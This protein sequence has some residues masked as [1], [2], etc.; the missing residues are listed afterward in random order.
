MIFGVNRGFVSTLTV[1]IPPEICD[2]YHKWF[3]N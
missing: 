2:W 1:N 3:C